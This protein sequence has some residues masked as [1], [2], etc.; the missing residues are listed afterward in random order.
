MN[1][2]SIRSP[3]RTHKFQA[4]HQVPLLLPFWKLAKRKKGGRGTLLRERLRSYSSERKVLLAE[5]P[6]LQEIT[7]FQHKARAETLYF[8]AIAYLAGSAR[9]ERARS[10]SFHL[11]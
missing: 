9:H 6:P 5:T 7:A 11:C 10:C 1:C 3:K 8:N 4:F 2:S